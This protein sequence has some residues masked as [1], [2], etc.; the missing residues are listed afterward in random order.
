METLM[1]Q[2]IRVFALF[3]LLLAATSA[4]SET[5][6]AVL[7][8]WM[9][10]GTSATSLWVSNIT[11]HDLTVTITFYDANGTAHSPGSFNNFQ[12][13][14]TEIGAGKSGY[15][16]ITTDSYGYAVIE[17]A[18]KG[19][20][21]DPFGLVAYAHRASGSSGDWRAAIPINNGQPF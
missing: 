11:S 17:W 8:H 9:G 5:G 19:T 2:I 1:N 15:V 6:K 3:S 4:Y 7:S 13:S 14:N 16:S 21:S 12:N 20:D 10:T 18:N